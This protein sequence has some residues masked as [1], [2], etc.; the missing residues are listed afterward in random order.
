[1]FV[2]IPIRYCIGNW[3]CVILSQTGFNERFQPINYLNSGEQIEVI[4]LIRQ[5]DW[6]MYIFF[7]L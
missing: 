5:R 4:D 2:R 7:F 3:H 6:D 1:V